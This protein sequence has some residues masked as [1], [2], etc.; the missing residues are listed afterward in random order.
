MKRTVIT[1]IGVITSIGIGRKAFWSALLEGRSGVGEVSSFDSSEHRVHRGCEVR[2][3]AA[4]RF[5][6]RP[7]PAGT[8]RG[9]AM[10]VA[11]SAMALED[12]GIDPADLEATRVGVSMGTTTGEQQAVERV[13]RQ[14]HEG[15]EEQIPK[16]LDRILPCAFIP[17]HVSA[18][19]RFRGPTLMIPTACAAGNYAIGYGLDLIRF[20]RA[21]VMLCGGSDPFSKVAFTG[22]GRL[23][24]VTPDV[25]RPFDKNR[26]GMLVGEG[27]GVLVLEPLER[28]LRRGAP[29]YAEVLGYGLTCDGYHMTTPHPDGVGVSA[30]ITSALRNAGVS[31]DS[32]DYIS[33]HGTGTKTNDVAETIAIKRVFGDHADRLLVSSIKSMIGHTMGA[34][35][36]IEAGVCAMA[37]AEGIAP[38]TMNYEMPDPEC[39]LDVVPNAP[40]RKALEVALNNGFAFGGNNSCLVLGRYEDDAPGSDGKAGRS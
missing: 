1:G 9:S 28:A 13:S 24:A 5:L 17:A 4:D 34:A 31:P 23:G 35:S 37:L 26:K 27:A 29:I 33:A 10:A 39:D 14:R 2:D 8:D 38:P 21:D 36:A 6:S 18:Y 3:F 11:A 32:V 16:A 40:R 19:F 7:L 25:C 22:F 12:A 15:G 30:A 20:G